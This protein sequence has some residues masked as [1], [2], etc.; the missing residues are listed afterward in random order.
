[1]S[2]NRPQR[3]QHLASEVKTAIATYFSETTVHG[4]RYV[5]EGANNCEKVFW[6]LLISVGF[7]L[8]GCIILKSMKDW[9]NTPLQT[10]IAKVSMPIE[11][12]YQP[13]I[14]VCNPQELQMP[15]RN[16][17]MYL[18]KLLNW[19]DVDKGLYPNELIVNV[20]LKCNLACILLFKLI[21]D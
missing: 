5:A 1:M 13:A 3:R 11:K 14:T 6:G 15:Y 18:E 20:L 17:W 10:T 4:F 21:I 16:R 2:I 12:L 9:E 7:V 19:I 8:S